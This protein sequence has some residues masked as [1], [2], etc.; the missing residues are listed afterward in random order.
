MYNLNKTLHPQFDQVAV[1]THDP[2]INT[3]QFMPHAIETP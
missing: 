2:W 3:E 1:Q